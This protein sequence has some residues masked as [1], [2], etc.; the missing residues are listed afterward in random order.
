MRKIKSTRSDIVLDI[1]AL[2]R[3][4]LLKLPKRAD[5]SIK[6][7]RGFVELSS[8]SNQ[9]EERTQQEVSQTVGQTSQPS[10]PSQFSFLDSLAG[11]GAPTSDATPQSSTELADIR[12]R[13]ENLEYKLERLLERLNSLETDS[14]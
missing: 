13:L 7:D 14:P 3:K 8:L 11:A 5:A 12:V 9:L 2:E 4:G 1:P 6:L 10:Q